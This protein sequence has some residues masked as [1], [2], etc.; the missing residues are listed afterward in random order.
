MLGDSFLWHKVQRGMLFTIPQGFDDSDFIL[1]QCT[2]CLN[3][4]MYLIW[5]ESGE[6][7]TVIDLGINQGPVRAHSG[8]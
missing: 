7:G 6:E 2:G 8:S 4:E 1:C 3:Q 5:V